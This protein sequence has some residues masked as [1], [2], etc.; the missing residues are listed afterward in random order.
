MSKTSDNTAVLRIT[1]PEV[2]PSPWREV[3]VRLSMNLKKLHDT[4]QAIFGWYDYHLWE[5]DVNEKRYGPPQDQEW[6]EE[7]VLLAQNLKLEKLIKDDVRSFLYVY[8]FGDHWVH[9]IEIF[10]TAYVDDT[11]MRL[12][13]FIK[14]EYRAPPEDIGGPPGYEYFLKEILPNPNHPERECYEHLINDPLEGA[15][16]INDIQ[17]DVIRGLLGRVARKRPKSRAA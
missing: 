5:F 7:K 15:F 8:D 3:E 10:S 12:P 16:D 17:P 6:G 2:S 11:D 1:L 4:I 9:H 14:G 13:R